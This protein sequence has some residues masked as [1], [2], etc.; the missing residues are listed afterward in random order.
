MQD[1]RLDDWVSAHEATAII[2]KNS[3]HAIDSRQVRRLALT[4]H[5]TSRVIGLRTKVYLRREVEQ[6]VVS[7]TPGRK[8]RPGSRARRLKRVA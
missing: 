3:G 5:I 8:P 1:E 6:I 2:S 7:T 4:G